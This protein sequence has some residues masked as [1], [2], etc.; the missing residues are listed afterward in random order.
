MHVIQIHKFQNTT[1]EQRLQEIKDDFDGHSGHFY[2]V[3][4]DNLDSLL[5]E[6]DNIDLEN[7]ETIRQIRK[8]VEDGI[9]YYYFDVHC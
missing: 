4:A 3:T 5:E 7:P 1:P 9:P 6:T 8:E 2:R